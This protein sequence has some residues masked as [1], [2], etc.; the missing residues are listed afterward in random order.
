MLNLLFGT[1]PGVCPVPAPSPGLI[2]DTTLHYVLSSTFIVSHIQALCVLAK[3]PGQIYCFPMHM[4]ATDKQPDIWNGN[5]FTWVV[6]T[7]PFEDNF[8]DAECRNSDYYEDFYSCALV[9]GA[10][11]NW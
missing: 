5:Q 11:L 4:T 3:V 2:A 6:L 7:V 1:K 9:L 8:A 10:E